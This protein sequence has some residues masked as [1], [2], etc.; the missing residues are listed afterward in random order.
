MPSPTATTLPSYHSTSGSSDQLYH[1]MRGSN[2]QG[3]PHRAGDL[4]KKRSFDDIVGMEPAPKR[5]AT[6]VNRQVPTLP[7]NLPFRNVPHLPAPNLPLSTN[8]NINYAG[9]PQSLPPL[10]AMN[11]RAMAQVYPSTPNWTPPQPSIQQHQ[12]AMT[13]SL[14]PIAATKLSSSGANLTPGLAPGLAPSYGSGGAIYSIPSSHQGTPSRRHSPRSVGLHS[15][16]SSPITGSFAKQDLNHYSPSIF[17]QQRNSPYKPV[18]PPNKLLYPPPGAYQE[19]YQHDQPGVE[20]MHYQPLGKRNDYRTGV[21]PEYRAGPEPAVFW[22]QPYDRN[23][24][25][26]PMNYAAR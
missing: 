23:L 8:S 3:P 25:T 6:L 20:Q 21:V 12:P 9:L 10:P 15:M 22:Q 13:M 24:D 16:T 26:A 18:R 11:G 19:Y 7:S 4:A 2:V 5:P 14:P 17:L 1:G